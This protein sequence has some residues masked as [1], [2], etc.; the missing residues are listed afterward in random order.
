MSDRNFILSIQL[1]MT[2]FIEKNSLENHFQQ[3][4]AEK[5]KSK[6]A[7]L[8][9]QPLQQRRVPQEP[10][11]QLSPPQI[12]QFTVQAATSSDL[13]L[14]APN[15]CMQPV[16]KSI[17]QFSSNHRQ[18]FGSYNSAFERN[19]R[20]IFGLGRPTSLNFRFN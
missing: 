18:L 7:L 16:S 20:L 13:P 3:L 11:K 8:G 17:P 14:Y 10:L 2:I 9:Q 5:Q 15:S 19:D 12:N 6:L 1:F 4:K